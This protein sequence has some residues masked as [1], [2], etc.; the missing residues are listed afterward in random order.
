[1]CLECIKK[2]LNMEIKEYFLCWQIKVVR[3]SVVRWFTFWLHP[4]QLDLDLKIKAPAAGFVDYLV[5]MSKDHGQLLP[6]Q[7]SE[8]LGDSA[9]SL[10]G[11]AIVIYSGECV[12]SLVLTSHSTR[13]LLQPPW[14]LTLLQTNRVLFVTPFQCEELYSRCANLQPLFVL[15]SFFQHFSFLKKKNNDILPVYTIKIIEHNY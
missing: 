4:F 11:L 14:I 5:S 6:Q 9:V 3:K 13:V 10:I 1:M 2:S 7:E 12:N 15:R 8:G